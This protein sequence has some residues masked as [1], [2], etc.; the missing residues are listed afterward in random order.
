MALENEELPE[1]R[2]VYLIVAL[3]DPH[4]HAH[5]PLNWISMLWRL[6]IESLHGSPDA[7]ATSE[8]RA[9]PL[10]C[11]RSMLYGLRRAIF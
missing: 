8:E 2:F 10:L 7:K 4:V 9:R 3:N 11:S 5:L 6:G 1:I